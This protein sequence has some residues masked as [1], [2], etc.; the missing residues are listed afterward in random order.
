[1]WLISGVK[2]KHNETAKRPVENKSC[3]PL[4]QKVSLEEKSIK[5]ITNGKND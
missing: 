3:N 1:M 5:P 4:Q 2:S